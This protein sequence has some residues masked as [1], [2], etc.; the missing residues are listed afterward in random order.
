MR[1]AVRLPGA[2]ATNSQRKDGL[3][4]VFPRQTGRTRYQDS[5]RIPQ[6]G[7][8]PRAS[9]LAPWLAPLEGDTIMRTFAFVLVGLLSVFTWGCR[10]QAAQQAAQ[11]CVQPN[12]ICGAPSPR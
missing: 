12:G 4:A 1:G 11:E 7:A 2:S 5:R 6:V 3:A 10:P 8:V 9:R